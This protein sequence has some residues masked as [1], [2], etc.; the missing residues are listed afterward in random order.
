MGSKSHSKKDYMR[1]Y[2]F[3][4]R[5]TGDTYYQKRKVYLNEKIKCECCN[6]CIGRQNMKR[7]IKIKHRQ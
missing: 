7:H 3:V 2:M 6:K 5:L 4:R 1:E